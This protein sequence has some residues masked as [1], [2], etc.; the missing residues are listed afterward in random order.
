MDSLSVHRDTFDSLLRK[1]NY[2]IKCLRVEDDPLYVMTQLNK[3]LNAFLRNDLLSKKIKYE[4]KCSNQLLNLLKSYLDGDP[5]FQEKVKDFK[6]GKVYKTCFKGQLSVRDDS[7][8]ENLPEMS[9]EEMQKYEEEILEYED[10]ISYTLLDALRDKYS[11]FI[12]S[13]VFEGGSFR[14]IEE[15][16]DYMNRFLEQIPFD[17]MEVEQRANNKCA[18]TMIKIY[19]NYLYGG[20]INRDELEKYKNSRTYKQS[21]TYQW[22]KEKEKENK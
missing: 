8:E 15:L 5:T 18:D 14:I 1:F 16:N 13:I 12:W 19:R 2:T 4:K 11:Y 20:K 17:D 3:L 9:D 21:S 22:R 7:E 10:D 6:S